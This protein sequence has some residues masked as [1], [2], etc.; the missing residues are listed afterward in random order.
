MFKVR[1]RKVVFTYTAFKNLTSRHHVTVT[2]L[3]LC[4]CCGSRKT[5][6]KEE[7][8]Q[9]PWNKGKNVRIGMPKMMFFIF[10]AM[11]MAASH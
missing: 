4:T 3:Q 5:G 7:T 10:E 2:S 9:D 8:G 6:D 11:F 1:S